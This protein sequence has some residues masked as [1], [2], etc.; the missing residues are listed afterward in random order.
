MEEE[1]QPFLARAGR[2]SAPRVIG[3][4]LHWDL[5]FTGTSVLLV[6]TGVGLVNAAGAL[7]AAILRTQTEPLVVSAGSAG[8]LGAEVQVGDVVLGDEYV[9]SDVDV[10]AF[11]YARGQIPGMPARYLGSAAVLAADVSVT[12]LDGSAIPVKRGLIA[13]SDTFVTGC[14]VERVLRYFPTALAAD[15]ESAALA[16]TAYVYGLPFISVRGISDLCVPG[17]FNM[18]IDDAA[19]RSAAVVLEALRASRFS[20]L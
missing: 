11:G 9:Q 10:S 2:T 8:G 3:A 15:M 14:H 13:S 5:D 7:T 16:Q 18:H 19:D 4:A 17:D 12:I 20:A 6:R 1:A